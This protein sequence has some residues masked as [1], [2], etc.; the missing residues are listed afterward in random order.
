MIRRPPRSTLFPYT[1]LFRSRSRAG[2]ARL[3]RR[4]LPPVPEPPGAGGAAALAHAVR[5]AAALDPA[6]PAEH[7]RLPLRGFRVRGLP[8]S[9]ADPRAG[10]RVSRPDARE[11]APPIELRESPLHGLGVFATA[12]IERGR[13]IVGS[14]G[15]RITHAQARR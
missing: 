10:G 1:T 5:A 13:R 3:D 7:L 6:P 4:R 8:A 2:R 15:E 12:R 14:P 11:E 9:C